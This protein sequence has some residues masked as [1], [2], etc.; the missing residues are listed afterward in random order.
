MLPLENQYRARDL[1]DCRCDDRSTSSKKALVDVLLSERARQDT[2]K[3]ACGQECED[4]S[5]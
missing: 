3:Q 2:E 1:Q 5:S 4:D